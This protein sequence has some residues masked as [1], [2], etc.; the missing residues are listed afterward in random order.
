MNLAPVT[1]YMTFG[2][3]GLETNSFEYV[4]LELKSVI[5]LLLR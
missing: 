5:E 4:N 2:C 1:H 3:I